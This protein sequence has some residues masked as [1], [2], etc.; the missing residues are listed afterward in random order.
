MG[1]KKCSIEC[2]HGEDHDRNN[3]L[4]ANAVSRM[5]KQTLV[6]ELLWKKLNVPPRSIFLIKTH[7]HEKL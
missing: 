4:N 6:R 7:P 5:M 3:I 2:N 1:F